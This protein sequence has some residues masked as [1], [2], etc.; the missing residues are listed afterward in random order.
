MADKRMDQQDE[1]VLKWLLGQIFR[2]EKR[3]KQLDERLMRINEERKAPIG[4]QGYEPLPRVSS[5]GNGAASILFKL[6]DIEERIYEQKAE[7]EK[8]IVRVMDILDYLPIDSIGR[9]ICE[10]RHLDMMKWKDIEEEIPMSH[11]QVNK[12]YRKAIR[13]LLTFNRIRQ[14]VEEN[15]QAFEDYVFEQGERRLKADAKRGP[16]NSSGGSA[17]ENKSRNLQGRLP[18]PNRG[19]KARKSVRKQ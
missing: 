13:Q 10:L 16:K 1:Q 8:C 14:M 5:V 18:T 11:S 6:A 12:N 17:S 15:R 3:K 7:I 4:G 2:A 9:E 19:V